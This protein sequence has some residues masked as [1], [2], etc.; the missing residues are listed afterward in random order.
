MKVAFIGV[1]GH[2]NYA[3]SGMAD[4]KEDQIV[5]VAKTIEQD[6]LAKIKGSIAKTTGQGPGA[7]G[8]TTNNA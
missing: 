2:F 1:R 8:S 4:N 6:E 3:V 5:A 7:A